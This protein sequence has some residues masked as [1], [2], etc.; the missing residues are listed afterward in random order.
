MIKKTRTSPWAKVFGSNRYLSQG[1]GDDVHLFTI[2]AASH[3]HVSVLQEE[4]IAAVNVLNGFAG[5]QIALTANSNVWR[6][7]ID[8]EYKCVAEKLWDWWMP[9]SGRVGVPRKPFKDIEDYV[10]RIAR[11][12]PVYVVRHGEP[13]IL[14]EYETFDQYYNSKRAVGIDV[15]GREISFIPDKRD[16]D[17]HNSCYWYNA[18]IS[19]YYTVENRANDQQPPEELMC[20]PALTLG[21]L[22]ALSEANKEVAYYSWETLRSTRDVA[23]REGL[24]GSVGGIQLIN[25]AI[26]MLLLARKGLQSR[27]L[28]E[29]KFLDPIEK[30]IVEFKCP[31]DR[32][33]QIVENGG[34]DALVDARKL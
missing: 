20:V 3:V 5:A 18:R 4:A 7:Q 14:K 17:L 21:L 29:E 23:C 26:R 9:D 1:D 34:I 27:G 16:I 6:G 15:E 13:I 24:C 2:N 33:A 31:A 32:A 10:D 19:R 25:L 22:S 12:R 11:F 28:G 8:P 30:R